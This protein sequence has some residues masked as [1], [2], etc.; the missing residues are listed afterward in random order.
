MSQAIHGAIGR[1]GFLA[2][3]A[4]AAAATAI[5]VS[6]GAIL[7]P[8]E[9]WGYE[10]KALK[11]GTMRTLVRMARDIYPHDRLADRF[12]V[13]AVKPQDEAAAK[14]PAIRNLLEN[15]VAT[16]DAAAK[17]KHGTPFVEVGWEADRV[18]LLRGME[19]DPFF[20]KVRGGLV[21]GL[22]NNQEVWP[23][24]GYEGES[25]SKGGYLERGFD[26][27]EWL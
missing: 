24:F 19:T 7:K 26:D 17:S 15:G 22:Y 13:V 27:I 1:R 21:T 9:A 16:L 3:T 23:L 18:R 14:D 6:G 20:Q 12:Y 4:S 25:A 11:P 8:S 10:V 5:L 2:G